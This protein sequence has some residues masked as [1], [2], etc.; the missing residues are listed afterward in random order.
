MRGSVL[1]LVAASPVAAIFL[2]EKDSGVATKMFVGAVIDGFLAALAFVPVLGDLID[3]VAALAAL[4][5]VAVRFRQL[6]GRLPGGMACLALFAFLWFEASLLPRRLSTGGGHHPLLF[7]LAAIPASLLAG[8]L[9]LGAI[10]LLLGLIY[11]GDRPKAIFQT[12][13]FPFYLM[14]FLVTI[15]L[16]HHDVERVRK[17]AEVARRA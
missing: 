17:A 11:D 6:L 8:A 7:Y 15:F 3:A 13:G 2:L 1:L 4:V 5:L 14:V 16:P 9:L 10:A 12:V